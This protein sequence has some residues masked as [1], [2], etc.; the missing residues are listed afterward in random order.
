MKKFK[1]GMT[2]RAFAEEYMLDCNATQAAIRAGYSKKTAGQIGYELLRH[3]SVKAYVQSLCTAR[4][5]QI[6]TV[7]DRALD[8]LAKIAFGEEANPTISERIRALQALA[9][10]TAT[11]E[12]QAQRQLQQ[13]GCAFDSSPISEAM[14]I[15]MR[16]NERKAPVGPTPSR[17]HRSTVKSKPKTARAHS[18]TQCSKNFQSTCQDLLA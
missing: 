17:Q 1:L 10:I 8:E 18:I 12:K 11:F 2:Q 13:L 9:T 16:L 7:S 4:L 6:R 5:A 15:M 14:D 3:P